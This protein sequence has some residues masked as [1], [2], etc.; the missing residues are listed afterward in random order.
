[1]QNGGASA[2]FM[3][4]LFTLV[5]AHQAPS[6][7]GQNIEKPLEMHHQ[8]Q[9]H[10]KQ[11]APQVARE[12][13]GEQVKNAEHINKHLDGKRE[14]TAKMTP[15]QLQFHY[16]NMH[17]LDSD[18]S[19]DGIELIKAITHFDEENRDSRQSS[20]QLPPPVITELEI[21]RML[22]PIFDSDDIN[23]DGYISYAEFSIAQ[24]QRD[25]QMRQQYQ[26]QQQKQQ[27]PVQ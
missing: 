27:P 24:K 6:F 13:G 1:M 11:A 17:D 7:P 16:F 18:E 21:E 22:D 9:M 23:R 26:Q 10:Q 19:L 12:F 5:L 20:T 25:E 3:L 8:G 14:P 2:V 4:V 15:E